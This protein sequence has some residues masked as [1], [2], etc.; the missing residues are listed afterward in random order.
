MAFYVG[1]DV[2]GTFTDGVVAD[3]RGEVRIFKVP[4]VP[5]EPALGFLNCLE[6][7]AASFDL[8][9]EKFLKDVQSLKYGTTIGTNLL[10]EGKTAKTGLITTKGFRDTLIIQRAGREYLGIDLQVERPPSLIPRSFIEEVTERVDKAGE[11]ITPLD[12]GDVRKGIKRLAAKGVEAFAVCLLWSFKNSAHERAIRQAILK[13]NPQSY[14]SVSSEI[15]PLIGE[16]E[17]TATTVMNASLGPPIARH[18]RGLTEKLSAKGLKAPLLLMQSTG[19]V[20]PAQD[21]SL[22]PITLMNSG[23]AGG[24][25]GSKYLGEMLGLKNLICVDMGG[26]SLDSSLITGGCYSASVEPRVFNHNLYVPMIDIYS[27]GAGGGSIARVDMA[28]RLKVGPQSAGADPGPACYGKGGEEPTVTDADVV[29]GRINPQNFLGGEMPL[30]LNRAQAAI[31]GKVARPLGMDVLQAAWG[32]CR[33]VDA[34]M[35]GAIRSI[36]IRKGYDP[37]NYALVAFGGAGPVHAASLAKEIGISTIVIPTMATAQSAFGIMSSD[38]VHTFSISDVMGA[39]DAAALNKRFSGLEQQGLELLAREG[40]SRKDF[41]IL[42]QAEMRY[43]GQVHEV[44][45]TVPAK[46]L[47]DQDLKGLVASFERNY[48][49]LY[50]RGTVFS[51]AGYEIVSFRVDVTGRT[52]KPLLAKLKHQGASPRQA[53]KTVRK[54]VFDKESIATTVFDGNRLEPGNRIKGPAIVEYMGTTAVIPPDFTGN[55]DAYQNLLLERRRS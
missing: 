55:V 43:R 42:R 34:N 1:I 10:I 49:S 33:V 6:K 4:S 32:I 41:S 46:P 19:G 16:Y 44:T 51:E 37:R 52:K 8:P 12:P 26:T 21:A 3:D 11:V 17:R 45:V 30:D 54:V 18:L 9:L 39:D 13:R 50:G 20:T 25:I 35:A 5:R 24:V 22:R 15:A 14:V 7:A 28:R 23:P 38:V 29:L 48:Q 27:I 40:F 47:T 36:S 2:G 53:R 31:A